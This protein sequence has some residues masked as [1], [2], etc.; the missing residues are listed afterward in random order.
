[1]YA[2]WHGP[3][4][5]QCVLKP[6]SHSS[7][8][9]CLPAPMITTS[10][11]SGKAAEV[12]KRWAR[13]ERL[14]FLCKCSGLTSLCGFVWDV[15]GLVIPVLLVRWQ[16][17]AVTAPGLVDFVKDGDFIPNYDCYVL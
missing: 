12:N 5:V 15:K 16:Q 6:W 2:L 9:K 4:D 11:L 10:V 14:A 13:A 17:R 3:F 1:M 8:L 7:Q